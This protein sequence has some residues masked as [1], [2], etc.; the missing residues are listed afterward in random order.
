MQFETNI[1]CVTAHVQL[2]YLLMCK[3]QYW[4]LTYVDNASPFCFRLAAHHSSTKCITLSLQCCATQ[5]STHISPHGKNLLYISRHPLGPQRN[6][7]L[8]RSSPKSGHC[9]PSIRRYI[10]TS[11]ALI[12]SRPRSLLVN[13]PVGD[14]AATNYWSLETKESRTVELCV[15]LALIQ[16]CRF[17]CIAKR[18]IQIILEADL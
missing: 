4:L 13:Q 8:D 10:N 6:T 18:L 11:R 15:I 2:K 16:W 12:H 7:Y 1:T 3:L 14:A 17:E 9:T 5:I